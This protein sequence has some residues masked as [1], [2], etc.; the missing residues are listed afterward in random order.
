MLTVIACK[1]GLGDVCSHVSTALF[2][3]EA[4]TAC[5]R[6]KTADIEFS[7]SKS[8]IL[9]LHIAIIIIKC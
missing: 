4:S 3:I 2:Y 1:A 5:C 9:E 7:N 8:R 6:V